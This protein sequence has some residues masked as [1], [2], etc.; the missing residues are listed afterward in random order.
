MQNDQKRYLLM[1]KLV[2]IAEE[3]SKDSFKDTELIKNFVSGGIIDIK[4]LYAQPFEYLNK[5]K[6]IALMNELPR[7]TDHTDG[8]WRRMLI[9]PFDADFNDANE[10]TDIN[11]DKKLQMEM[12]GIF[13]YAIVGLKRLQNNSRF[14]NSETIKQELENYS[15][16]TNE[17]KA[18][19]ME[20]VTQDPMAWT[21]TQALY[22]GYK[23]YCEKTGVRYPLSL[24]EFGKKLKMV[25][26]GFGMKYETGI[27]KNLKDGNRKRDVRGI[28]LRDNGMHVVANWAP[29]GMN[30]RG[31]EI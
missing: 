19:F 6:L 29:E 11:I 28:K 2:N 27:H 7:N 30:I 5:T 20:E 13:N 31:R 18:W 12:P 24:N 9:V 1:N 26:K 4:Q 25:M 21:Q 17:V 23:E 16:D 22:N 14:T 8:F 10:K 3:N 15:V